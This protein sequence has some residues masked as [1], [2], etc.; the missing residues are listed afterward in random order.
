MPDHVVSGDTKQAL[1]Q[2]KGNSHKKKSKKIGRDKGNG[3]VMGQ[4]EHG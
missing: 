1:W 4:T 3:L 2:S